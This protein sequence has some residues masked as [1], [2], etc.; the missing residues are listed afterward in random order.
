ML[1]H[2]QEFRTHFTLWNIGP[3]QIHVSCDG[4]RLVLCNLSPAVSEV[5]N[6]T[7]Q[8]GL[9]R[10][11]TGAFEVCPAVPSAVASLAGAGRGWQGRQ[12]GFR[13]AARRSL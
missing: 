10:E 3:Q 4:G 6:A 7:R 5:F 1:R 2:R 8:I 12:E 9:D 13:W 11:S